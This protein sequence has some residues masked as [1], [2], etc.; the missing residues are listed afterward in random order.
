[1][2]LFFQETC[3]NNFNITKKVRYH[4][5]IMGITYML[6][7]CH[8]QDNILSEFDIVLHIN[9][10]NINCCITYYEVYD[11]PNSFLSNA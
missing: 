3:L 1:M 9:A 8:N 7:E 2:K 10:L 6:L 5:A 4:S 11:N